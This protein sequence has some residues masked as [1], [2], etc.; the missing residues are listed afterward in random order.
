MGKV[1]KQYEVQIPKDKNIICHRT[2]GYR[3]EKVID[4]HSKSCNGKP[5]KR[6]VLI[7]YIASPTTMYPSSNYQKFY[8]ESWKL[9]TGQDVKCQPIISIGLKSVVE[10]ICV[11]SGLDSI[12]RSIFGTH[13]TNLLYDYTMFTLLTKQSSAQHFKSTMENYSIFSDKLY[14]D[15][16]FS[17]RIKSITETKRNEFNNAWLKYN[18]DVNKDTDIDLLGDGSTFPTS[19]I[20]ISSAEGYSKQPLDSGEKIIGTTLLFGLNKIGPLSLDIYPGNVTDYKGLEYAMLKYK[21]NNIRI[22]KIVLDRG[23]CNIFVIQYLNSL[24]I[25]YEIML[26]KDVLAM[27]TLINAFGVSLKIDCGKYWINDTNL[28]GIVLNTQIFNNNNYCDNVHLFFHPGKYGNQVVNFLK[29]F[30]L[31]MNNIKKQIDDNISEIIISKEFNNIIKIVDENNKKEVTFDSN[32]LTLKLSEYGFIGIINH[33]VEESSEKTVFDYKARQNIEQWIDILKNELGLFT[34]RVHS[35]ES[36]NGKIQLILV[37]SIIYYKILEAAK[38][39]HKTVQ[40]IIRDLKNIKAQFINGAYCYINSAPKYIKEFLEALGGDESIFDATVQDLND[41][42][43]NYIRLPRRRKPGCKPI[44]HHKKPGVA[45][46]TKRSETNKDGSP[47]KKPGRPA[48]PEK[49]KQR[50]EAQAKREA[51]RQYDE[52]GKPIPLRRGRPADPEKA[53][54]RAEAK[55]KREARRKYDENGN[56][57]HLRRGRIPTANTEKNK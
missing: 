24:H 34:L 53:K 19:A 41:R 8:P 39:V 56:P 43:H 22:N 2:N 31:E 48:D 25:S 3:V 27:K 54:Q 45:V 9:L 29:R 18:I 37:S 1:Y 38:I 32:A 49:A 15:S 17:N 30:C 46:G 26:D 50:A 35:D 51:R 14:S 11:D 36:L 7:G 55:A 44:K 52:N 40:E 33:V 6:R 13:D 28:F 16:H 42:L 20:C 5:S 10:L 23:Y 4:S 57:L 21:S 12:M 47:R